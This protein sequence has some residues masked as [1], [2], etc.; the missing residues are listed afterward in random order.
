[1]L[2]V[3]SRP[4]EEIRH[5]ITQELI[6]ETLAC[7][8]SSFTVTVKDGVVTIEGAPETAAV[9]HDIIDAARHVEGVVTVRDRLTCPPA[10]DQSP[11]PLF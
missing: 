2:S 6:R 10:A 1:V 8:P 3:Y 5:E 7:D 11:G 9:G 4:D